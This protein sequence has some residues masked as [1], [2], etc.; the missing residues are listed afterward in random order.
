MVAQ[1]TKEINECH[2]MLVDE[3]SQKQRLMVELE[4][5]EAEIETLQSKLQ[6]IQSET[7]SVDS[8]GLTE[9]TDGGSNGE[10]FGKRMI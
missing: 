6:S 10:H 7:G 1:F 4:C 3:N 9:S 5:K 8:A 2:A